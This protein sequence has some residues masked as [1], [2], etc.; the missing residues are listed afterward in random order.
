MGLLNRALNRCILSEMLSRLFNSHRAAMSAF[1]VAII[2]LI[3]RLIRLGE[4]MSSLF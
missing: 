4:I 3:S 2:C 1:S